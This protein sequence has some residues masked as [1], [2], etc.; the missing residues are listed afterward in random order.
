[1]FAIQI[2]GPSFTPP[3]N[4]AIVDGQVLTFSVEPGIYTVTET[5]PGAG[6]VTT[7]TVNSI[8]RT[9][10]GVVNLLNENN[11]TLAA[12]PIS[13]QV[14]RDFNSDG[15]ITANGTI[16]DTGVANVTIT[17]YDKAG[18]NVGS[19]VTDVNGDYTINPTGDGPYRI[20]FSDLPE[21]YAPTTHGTANGTSV[22]FVNSAADASTINLG[23][24]YPE[25]YCQDNPAFCTN[26][27]LAGDINNTAP[28]QTLF[29][30]DYEATADATT[31]VGNTSLG[32]KAQVG[33]TY[34][35]AYNANNDSLYASAY[36]KRHAGLGP[37]GLG[38]IY[39]VTDA[40]TASPGTPA[41]LVDLVA[42]GI[43]LGQASVPSNAARGLGA[44][45]APTHDTAVYPLIGKVGLGDIDFSNEDHLLWATN[46]FEKTLLRIP[47][48]APTNISE[49]AIPNPSCQGGDYRPFGVKVY[50]G[51]V[52]VGIICDAQ[53]L[54][55]QAHLQ[56]IVY[57]FDP[58]SSAFTTLFS[59]PL[60][61]AKGSAYSAV[62]VCDPVGRQWYPWLDTLPTECATSTFTGAK[63]LIHPQPMLTDIEFD[64]D[65]AM[66]LGLRDRLGDQGGNYNFG[67]NTNDSTT[68]YSVISGGDVLRAANVNGT[69][70]LE[71]NGTVGTLS[72]GV[73]N[74][75]GP[76]GGEFY[77][78][79]GRIETGGAIV[80]QETSL[81]G[82]ALLPGRTELVMTAFDPT[83]GGIALTGGVAFLSNITGAKTRGLL[84][85]DRVFN[86]SNFGKAAGLGD[87][88]LLCDQAPI[89]IGNRVWDDIDGDGEQDAGEPG[90]NGLT[91]TLQ[92]PTGISTTTTS[93][94]GNYYFSVDAY[95]SYTITVATPDEYQLTLA[96]AVALDAVNL[97]SNDAISDTI[98]SDALLVNGMPTI[99]YTTGSAGQNNHGLDFGF[100][101][102]VAGQV[103]ILNVA[104]SL[105]TVSLGNRVWYD[106]NNNGIVD[107]AE[108]NVA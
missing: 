100:T 28:T 38:A 10:N 30:I 55:T 31:V 102:P 61:Y 37:N 67:L 108:Q 14:F 95:T 91:V 106:T 71:S 21:G 88:E 29:Q 39:E 44:P 35:L 82:L 34:G 54:N 57:K 16:T 92:T 1:Q 53:N 84:V 87:V 15:L 7:Y 5:S 98:D 2:E 9:T 83:D 40:S 36:L 43:D 8:D 96:N 75:E 11:A 60:T 105:P 70:V 63:T 18:N 22:Q 3:T 107:G 50:R 27:L 79:D 58:G 20:E 32:T 56:A 13:G 59:T 6:W 86:S 73:G 41:L 104:P 77:V 19:A 68:T 72:G 76:D 23:V 65:G 89:E 49:F 17:A 99:L 51:N 94:D 93:G 80:H 47:V 25:E 12:T 46:L 64:V 69:F 74:G 45:T 48:D 85:Y 52:Y 24:G 97:F 26:M 62:A 101:Q 42:A 78:G 4:T 81:G 103:D 90:L 33:T 66:I